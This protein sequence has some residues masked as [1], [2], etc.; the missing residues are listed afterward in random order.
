[1]LFVQ[2]ALRAGGGVGFLPMWLAEADIAAGRL[3][4]VLPRHAQITGHAYIV[5]PPA[6]HVPLKVSAFRDLLIDVLRGRVES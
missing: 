3:V 6:K 2:A 1:M 5:H 4:P